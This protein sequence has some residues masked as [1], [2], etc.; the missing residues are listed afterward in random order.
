MDLKKIAKP[1]VPLIMSLL[2]TS[3]CVSPIPNYC[4]VRDKHAEYDM[5]RLENNVL[6]PD[7]PLSLEEVI[8]IAMDRNLDVQLQQLE[9]AFQSEKVFAQKLRMLPDGTGNADI[10]NRDSNPA[11]FSRT[12]NLPGGPGPIGP[13]ATQ[14]TSK[15]VRLYDLTAAWNVI[16]F[17]LSYVRTQQEKNRY[18]LTK[19]RNLRA[20]Q[21]LVLDIY[22]AYYRAIVA[23]QA[24]TQ[25]KV[26]ITALQK[27]QET[28]RRQISEQTVSEMQGLVNENRLIDL[29]IK[30]YAFDNE[31]KSALTEVSALM[32]VPPNSCFELA[33]AVFEEVEVG[34]I[35]ITEF[36]KMALRYRPELMAQEMQFTIDVEEVKASMI[37]MMPNARLFASIW[38]DD[39]MF[40]LFHDWFKFGTTLSWNFLQLPAKWQNTETLDVRTQVSWETRLSMSMGVLTQVHLSYINVQESRLQY[41][42][43]KDLYSVKDRQLAVARVLERSG[44]LSTD[45]VLVFEVEALFARVNAIKAFS[46]LEIALEQLSNSVGRPLLLSGGHLNGLELG[47]E[48]C[49]GGDEWVLFDASMIRRRPAEIFNAKET[50]TVRVEDLPP[51]DQSQVDVEKEKADYL[52]PSDSIKEATEAIQNSQDDELKQLEEAYNK[53]LKEKE[54]A[55]SEAPEPFLIEKVEDAPAPATETKQPGEIPSKP[56]PNLKGSL[57]KT[58][59]GI[60]KSSK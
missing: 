23:K 44:E 56:L 2:A 39:D 9:E 43:S 47:L 53:Y 40:I 34:D 49:C 52:E 45:D 20:R 8:S 11:W 10:N 31:Y 58:Q 24:I 30:L 1:Q 7:H 33:D 60:F 17:G 16:D 41:G 50:P 3:S 36:E 32:G 46:N 13:F 27:R 54:N 29:Q 12:V 5:C 18:L 26:L 15:W 38:H 35:C 28:L 6:L 14:S 22:R 57:E 21:N 25:S 48:N 51:P 19:Q 42:L 55:K 4:A 59:K 37:E